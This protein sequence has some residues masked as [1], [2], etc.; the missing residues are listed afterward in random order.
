MQET[1]HMEF[2]MLQNFKRFIVFYGFFIILLAIDQW[3]FGVLSQV[4]HPQF[5]CCQPQTILYELL[6][7]MS[8]GQRLL[9]FGL[10][11]I[12]STLF[13][14]ILY[15]LYR[16]IQNLQTNQTFTQDTLDRMNTMTKFYVGYA[17]FYPFYEM[18]YSVITSWHNSPGQRCLSVS[19]GTENINQIFIACCLFIV[20]Q[21]M[22][23]A[24]RVSSEYKMVI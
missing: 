7:H 17:V 1:N 12:G 18:A 21:V 13:I 11:S 24:Y 23:E 3:S 2:P 10:E 16:I 19:F 8:I 14:G 5:G 15:A 9:S 20:F 4:M 22:K 6:P